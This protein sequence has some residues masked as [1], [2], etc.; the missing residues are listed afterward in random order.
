MVMAL[1]ACGG[2]SNEEKEPTKAPT[3]AVPKETGTPTPTEAPS[4]PEGSVFERISSA[5]KQSFSKGSVTVVFHAS[6]NNGD[7]EREYLEKDKVVVEKDA[8][9]LF[10]DVTYSDASK[11]QQY[12]RIK[13]DGGV[14]GETWWDS[15]MNYKVLPISDD[16]AKY[17]YGCVNALCTPDGNFLREFAQLI[18]YVIPDWPKEWIPEKRLP[19]LLAAYSSDTVLAEVLGYQRTADGKDTFSIPSMLLGNLVGSLSGNSN[20]FYGFMGT[21]FWELFTYAEKLNLE[22][23]YEDDRIGYIRLA[24]SLPDNRTAEATFT[25]SDVGSTEISIPNGLKQ[26]EEIGNNYAGRT[27][28]RRI[29]AYDRLWSEDYL[30]GRIDAD[31][32]AFEEF[33]NFL[34]AALKDLDFNKTVY[35]AMNVTELE[36]VYME[37]ESFAKT[38]VEA[39]DALL[40]EKYNKK[41]EITSA[42]YHPAILTIW[43]V[44]ENGSV[45]P[46]YNYS[47]HVTE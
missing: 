12:A 17:M 1:T 39:L 10:S 7:E 21:G 2:G 36:I 30:A 35:D 5:I 34:V 33:W 18:A 11:T 22:V 14:Y 24:F 6:G 40:R 19:E 44:K 38:G 26:F 42:S 45:E 32:S 25:V 37:G 9:L 8:Y 28:A 4:V 41:F 16:D 13:K 43:L 27:D 15:K 47:V 3:S 23:S 46:Y 31:W 29:L 20:G